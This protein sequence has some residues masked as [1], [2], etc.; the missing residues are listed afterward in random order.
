M[1]KQTK[2]RK[3]DNAA[4]GI[5]NVTPIQVAFIVDRYLSD[6]SYVETRSVF[7][8]EASSLIAKSPIQ[9]APKSLLSLEAMLDEY[10]SL[11]EQKVILDQERS[12]LE[13]EK[14]RVH[15][16]LQG[17]Q[18]VMS[19]Y[20]SSGRSSTP[21]IS[22]APDKVGV[23]GQS[24]SPVGCPINI[25]QPV[26]PEVTPQNSNGG[27]QSFITPVY[28]DL[29][30]N[31]RKS[32]KTS[33]VV[34]PASKRS[35]NK[36]STKK[37][38]S[39]DADALSQST[40]AG[41]DQPTVRHSNEIQSS[42]PTCPPTETVVQGSS[43][44]KC[45]FNQPSFSIPTNSSGPKT[46]PRANSC[47][48]DK[49]T[50]PHEISSAADCSNINTPQD[51]SP[52]CCTVISSSK[53]VTISPYKQVAYYSVERNHSI[54]SPSPVKTNAKRQGKRDQVKGRLDFDVSDVPISSDK[55]I[56]NEIYAS[57]S[58]K[59]LDIFDIDLPSLDVFGEDFSFTEMLADLDMDC[60]VIGCSSVPTFGASTDT[61]SGSSHESM[62]CNV[63]TN[64]MMSEYSSTVTQILSGK[65]LNTE[66]MDSLTAV[67]S[68]TKCIRIL[69]PA[70]KL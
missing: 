28:N 33:I 66:G 54:L 35:R 24:E 56:E 57:E 62:D 11:K 34:P 9:E 25:K 6:N 68:T 4:K 55:G 41:N 42:S 29:E 48:S 14:I 16:L 51:V 5:R 21:S 37:S 52:T 22:A 23:V 69:S 50:S 19:A 46:P 8:V 12:Y 38:A 31:K 44:V 58:E 45:L 17:M 59:Q 43:V 65:E 20:N 15:A 63:G 2:A 18:T 1:G 3:S 39:K 10:I 61:L 47:Q 70:K 26:R 53:R 13:Q 27:P 32:S 40:E 60:E 49:S 7:R 30:A 67:K 64:Q 36:L